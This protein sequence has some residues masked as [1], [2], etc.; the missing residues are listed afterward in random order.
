MSAN[1]H[2][3]KGL[4][5][6]QRTRASPETK[7]ISA[8]RREAGDGRQETTTGVACETKP[9]SGNRLDAGATAGVACE[10]KPILLR[11]SSRRAQ[12][13]LQFGASGDARPTAQNKANSGAGRRPALREVTF[14][15]VGRL[16]MET[17]TTR[18]SYGSVKRNGTGK[19]NRD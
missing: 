17:F 9:I 4:G 14:P 3:G 12:P 2:L 16:Q 7:P 1:C 15:R 5:E 6:K 18:V 11:P 19:A 13:T 8:S 10:T